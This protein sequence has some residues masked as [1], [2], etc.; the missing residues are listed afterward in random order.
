[1]R[2]SYVLKCTDL[3]DR[4]VINHDTDKQ[5]QNALPDHRGMCDSGSAAWF[6]E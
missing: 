4:E 1:M 6:S 3:T 5:Q 2:Y